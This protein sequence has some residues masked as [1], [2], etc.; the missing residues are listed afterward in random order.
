MDNTKATPK[1]K[2][3]KANLKT[4]YLGRI[5]IAGREFVTKEFFRNEKAALRAAFNKAVEYGYIKTE[6]VKVR[7]KIIEEIV[8]NADVAGLAAGTAAG[9]KAA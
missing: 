3:S 9:R 6:P 2:K 7:V 1:A 5:D 4:R 8:P